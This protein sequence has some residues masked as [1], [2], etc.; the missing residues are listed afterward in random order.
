MDIPLNRSLWIHCLAMRINSSFD[1]SYRSHRSSA[2]AK[3]EPILS[4]K[5]SVNSI[6]SIRGR[7]SFNLFELAFISL[8]NGLRPFDRQLIRSIDRVVEYLVEFRFLNAC[9]PGEKLPANSSLLV[10]Q[11]DFLLDE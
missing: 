8:F 10:M 11:T 3:R 2:A 1:R 9:L 5:P 7:I 6:D 4:L